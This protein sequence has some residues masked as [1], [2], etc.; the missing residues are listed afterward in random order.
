MKPMITAFVHIAKK[1]ICLK[2]V[3]QLITFLATLVQAGILAFLIEHI[4]E[5]MKYQ[6]LW[7]I[8]GM[9]VVEVVLIVLAQLL[10]YLR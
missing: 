9:T 10:Q 4:K 1:S 3:H 6:N 2:V 7:T 8:A 5:M